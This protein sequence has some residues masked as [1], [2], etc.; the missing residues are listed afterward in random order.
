MWLHYL[1]VAVRASLADRFFS[2]VN[3]AGLAVGLASAA[4][5]FLYVRNEYSYDSWLE[6]PETLFRIDTVETSPG[7]APIEI[8]QAPG[9]LKA[10]LLKDFP[11][12][13]DAARAYV[14][15]ASVVRD[16]RPFS[17]EL[18]VADPNFFALVGLPFAAGTPERALRGTGSVAISARA[19]EKYFGRAGAVGGRLTI[20][21]PEP[22]DFTVS[23]VFATVPDNSHMAFD[24]VIPFDSY[25]AA[26]KDEEIRAIPDAWNGAY[27]HT[28]V[29][30]RDGAAAAAV[31]RGLPAFVDRHLPSWLSD[32]AAGS[33]DPFYRFRLVPV[34]DVHFDGAALAAMKPPASRPA[35]LAVST[36]AGL[37]LLIASINF[38]NLTTA[39]STLRA[40]E[41]ALRKAVG[42][43]RRQ[44]LVQFLG[45]ALLVTLC[46]GL[47][48]L[49]LVELTLPY[50]RGPL[51]LPAS[52]LERNPWELWAG[53]GAL[54]LA[55]AIGSGLYPS[56]VVARIRPARVFNRD[57]VRHGGGAL[58]NLL[59]V[60]QFAISI[61]L[62]AATIVMLLQARFTSQ[63]ELGFDP[64]NLLVVR[65]PDG[66]RRE[67]AARSLSEAVARHGDV[68]DV[69][70]SSA[71]PSDQSEDNVAVRLP[72]AVKPVVLG[73]HKVDS[74]FFRTYRVEP[75][76]GRTAAMRQ[77]G[78]AAADGEQSASAVVNR[79][80][81]DRLGITDP[82]DAIGMVV[83]GSDTA[84]TLVG[85][86]PDLHFRSLHEPVREEMFV[87]DGAPGGAVTIRYRTRDLPGLLRFVEQAWRER[88]PDRAIDRL[89]VDEALDALYARERRQTS[90]LGMFA[91]VAIV[92][93]CLGLLAMAAFAVQRR[94]R[95]IAIRKVLGARS[96]DI[97][98]LLLW[99][100][101]RPVLIANAIAWPAVW[102]LMRDWLNR[103]AYRIDLPLFAFVLAGLAA[104]LIALLAVG[105][106]I[107][108][109]ARTSPIA[110]L[111][112]E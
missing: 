91:G 42:A 46:A 7:Q 92:L 75:L 66:P 26:A 9:P 98:R 53:L 22:R 108:K 99:E 2:L 10:A 84:Y 109:V 40:R 111:R 29:R 87:L 55:T 3:L 100:F 15:P 68:L 43:K 62:I 80:A 50:L 48:A 59:V 41:V 14:A 85:V 4:F 38:A 18:L 35:V 37:I 28:Y 103:F 8:A 56:L 13:E 70:L 89:F 32:L 25:F 96:R 33:P 6:R 52:V 16:G 54:V 72:D 63:A 107:W 65:V 106:H 79:K 19:A 76:S 71:V 81:L 60:L 73:F 88:V 57:P 104:L 20:L 93:S 82:A 5:I 23:A 17:E 97:A 51:G 47:I 74:R 12:V 83:R 67:A 34:R 112:Y 86:V 110:A 101:S 69:A 44:I 95:E 11:Q 36:V 31:E 61:G 64:E 102:W 1:K 49:A 45:E 24:V 21:A 39:R 105:A 90:L 94:T 30:L 58:R 78:A 27:F 77:A